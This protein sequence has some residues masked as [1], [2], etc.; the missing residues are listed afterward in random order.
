MAAAG[1]AGAQFDL[2]KADLYFEQTKLVEKGNYCGSD[3]EMK[4]NSILKKSEYTVTL[5]LNLGM[6]SAWCLTSDFSVDF[7]N[8][9]A[10]KRS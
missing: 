6:E 3:A 10:D 4:V 5:D 1:R 7:V 8:I 2:E 9:N